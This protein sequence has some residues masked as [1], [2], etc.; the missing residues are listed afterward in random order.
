MKN[1]HKY[2]GKIL[3]SRPV[4][5]DDIFNRT[6]VVIVEDNDWGTIGFI[7]NKPM[8]SQVTDLIYN[9]NMDSLVYEGG[10]VNQH[11]LFY[12]HSR[13]DLIKDSIQIGTHFYWSGNF[14]DVKEA[15]ASKRIEDH[16]IRFFLGYSGWEEGQLQ[17]E[18][19]DSAWLVMENNF[20]L[21][22]KWNVDLWQRQLKI[23]GGKNLLWINMP[24]NPLLN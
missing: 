16:E 17:N 9:L 1:T 19:D 13:P 6:V 21:L 22:K 4:I 14:N 3:V 5:F 23:L 8:D 20:D 10:P 15:V 7:L 11:R 12:I 18:L 24:E 2:K